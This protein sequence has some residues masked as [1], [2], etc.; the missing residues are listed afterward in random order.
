M[1]RI[2]ND[3]QQDQVFLDGLS[4]HPDETLES[5][6]RLFY[7]MIHRMVV[8][9]SGQE[10][11]AKDIFQEGLIILYEKAKPGGLVLQCKL[12]TFLYSIC[13]NLWL[14]RLQQLNRKISLSN[15]VEEMVVEQELVDHQVREEEFFRMSAALIKLGEPCKSLLEDY[16][17]NQKTMQEIVEKFGYTNTDNAKNQKYKCLL[18]LKKMFFS[19]N[20]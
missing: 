3:R 20:Q 13:K 17:L 12:K 10:E 6:Y 18:R 8:N 2:T 15:G 7:P 5:L 14:K 16:Y 9:N 11:D 19:L 1:N 4:T